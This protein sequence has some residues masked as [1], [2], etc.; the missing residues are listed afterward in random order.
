[1]QGGEGNFLA[2]KLIPVINNSPDVLSD[3]V[4]FNVHKISGLQ[5]L[6]VGVF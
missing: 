6:K 5:V 1:M 2:E 3:D 4:K